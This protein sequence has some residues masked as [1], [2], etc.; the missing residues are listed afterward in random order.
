MNKQELIEEINKMKTQLANMEKLLEEY[1]Y[2]RW[3]PEDGDVYYYIKS[4][5]GEVWKTTFCHRSNSD[6]IHYNTY[7][8]FQTRE[9]AEVESEKILITHLLEEISKRLNRDKKFD[10]S[11][12]G[13]EKYYLYWDDVDK[14]ISVG[15]NSFNK[16]Q[17]AVYCLDK[18][19]KDV[20][21]QE[22]GEERLKKYL[23]GE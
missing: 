18:S 19:F 20:A 12:C 16:T 6:N 15:V 3:K 14:E 22:I 23:R 4:S 11:F 9:E 21:I 17:G 7:N 10:W 5:D 1:E 8:C 13:Q 2:E